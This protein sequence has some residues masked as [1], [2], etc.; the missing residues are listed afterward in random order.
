MADSR[1][2]WINVNPAWTRILG[3]T[4][5]ELVGRTSEWLEHPEDREATRAKIARLADGRQL[6][7]LRQ[8]LARKGRLL[9]NSLLVGDA[10]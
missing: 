10:G 5:R 6:A 1:G 2:V 9:P 7:H 4:E 3:W 8:P